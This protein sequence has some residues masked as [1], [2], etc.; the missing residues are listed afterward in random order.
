VLQLSCQR[1]IA[2]GNDFAIF[3]LQHIAD[4]V[5]TF[6]FVRCKFCPN[7][8]Q[9]FFQKSLIIDLELKNAFKLLFNKSIFCISYIGCILTCTNFYY[10]FFLQ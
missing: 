7:Q 5:R 8:L 9:M 4:R 1:Y 10:I 6:L 2:L 3:L